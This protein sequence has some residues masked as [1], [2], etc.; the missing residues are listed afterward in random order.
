MYKYTDDGNF[1]EPFTFN[2][3]SRR[4]EYIKIEHFSENELLVFEH[5][6]GK[7]NS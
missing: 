2:L 7:T 4:N 3:T 5:I 6:E 1:T